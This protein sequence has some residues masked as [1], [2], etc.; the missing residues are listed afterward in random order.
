MESRT[1]PE[2]ISL[3]GGG[4]PRAAALLTSLDLRAIL[5]P[6]PGNLPRRPASADPPSGEVAAIIEK[7]RSGGDSALS[8]LT[9]RFDGAALSSLEV[10]EEEIGA[11][12]ARIDP[13]LRRAL[14]HARDR[15]SAY[16]AHQMPSQ[17][18]FG[19]ADLCVDDV[20]RPV[21]RAGAYAPG[22]RARYPSTVLMTVVP[23]RVAG[24]DEVV[25]C[26]P[27][28]PDGTVDD[29]S[30]AA[31][32][33]ARADRVFRVGGAQA[34]AAMAYGTE[35]IPPVDVIAGPGN[36][37]VAEAERQVAGVVRVAAGFAGPSEVVVVAD[38]SAPAALAAID[39]A[40]QAEHGPD[41][42]AWLITWNEQVLSEVE[43][44]LAQIVSR[45]PRRHEIEGTLEK[46]G[47][48]VLV[49]SAEAAMEVANAIAPEHLELQVEKPRSYVDLV[50]DAG[51]VFLGPDAPA[52]IGD[53]AVGPN[54]VLPT[55]RSARYASALR[56]D[57]FLK[58]IHVVEATPVGLESI[59]GTVERLAE[60]EG[61][62]THAESIRV[63][64]G[65]SGPEMERIRASG[66][67]ARPRTTLGLVSGYHSPQVKVAVRLNTNES[68]YPPPEE[69]VKS[70]AA[71]VRA[72]PW[73][74]YP[75]RSASGLRS[76]IAAVHGV[77][78]GQVYVA[79]GSNEVIQ[80]LCLAYGGP[81]R[82]A[83]VFEP[84]YALH[85]HISQVTGTDVVSGDR[86]GD[87]AVDLGHATALIAER[88]PAITFLCS[89]NNPTGNAD[90]L[91]LTVG[92]LEAVAY[93]TEGLLVVDE[94]YGQFASS[95]AL[96][97]Q[98]HEAA[99]RLVVLRTFSKTWAM[100]GLRVG[101]AIAAPRVVSAVTEVTLPYHLDAAQQVAAELALEY[102]RDMES[103]VEEIVAERSR[104]AGALG[105]LPV[106]QWASD[107]N[108][109]LFR[110]LGMG[111]RDLWQA[112]LD[113]SVLVRDCSSWP[114]L[115]GCL[116][117]TVGTPA[118]DDAFLDALAGALS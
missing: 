71:A 50:R 67:P 79:N 54:H 38:G 9:A 111:G 2:S 4:T 97:L 59:A 60:A 30:L 3:A 58:H 66:S 88:R 89:P 83:L 53:Y 18:R 33:I 42:L 85:R 8:E 100:A 99:E 10:P 107:A 101:Y 19:T 77:G 65:R 69:L 81:G 46:Q 56:V 102:G 118:E 43:E 84:T 55:N 14:E 94:A 23:A 36:R 15:I 93:H 16:H 76:R 70:L 5:H 31:A 91:R 104:L 105:D 26:I 17:A 109:I 20:I 32:A 24:V 117:V 39:L 25:I 98:R 96:D 78:D 86:G 1:E 47:Y 74:R 11:A 45:A 63:R 41:G 92:V 57:D 116:R 37:Y 95:S 87:Y 52:T 6:G 28:R 21:R 108:F 72:I 64:A 61:L 112:L 48:A 35:S 110:P 80:S 49:A 114:G 22:G 51:A 40:V 115:E 103:R 34:I 44:A 12:L 82:E 27:P 90:P 68:P 75:D 62:S 29:A 106:R 7:V 13:D 73:N 113:R